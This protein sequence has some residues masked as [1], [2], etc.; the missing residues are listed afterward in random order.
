LSN[1]SKRELILKVA[2]KH[3][4]EYGYDKTVL[5]NI[6]KECNISKPAIYYHFRDKKSLYKE[7]ICDFF[8]RVSKEIEEQIKET[9]PILALEAYVKIFGSF[10]L[11][12]P[13]FSSI[14]AK[15]LAFGSSS[16][17]ECVSMLYLVLEK[18]TKILEDGFKL[19]VFEKEN[20]FMIQL[21]IVSTLTNYHTTK[22]LRSNISLKFQTSLELEPS[23]ENIAETLAQKILK[24]VKC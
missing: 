6:A 3:F 15:E 16:I 23:L 11:K 14:F 20:P 1:L 19:G 24:A 4:A 10:F 9:N 21:M 2:T 8:R 18:L 13:H 12:E 7:I 22:K 5:D 17:Q